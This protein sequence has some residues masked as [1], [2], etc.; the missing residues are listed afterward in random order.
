MGK[1]SHPYDGDH[2]NPQLDTTTTT[3]MIVKGSQA[4]GSFHFGKRA[5][6]LLR[7]WFEKF[8]LVL[9]FVAYHPNLLSDTC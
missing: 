8:S 9:V 1:Q 6:L 5:R 7:T 3:T 2:Y 4:H